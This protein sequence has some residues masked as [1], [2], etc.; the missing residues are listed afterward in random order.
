MSYYIGE[1]GLSREEYVTIICQGYLVLGRPIPAEFW[2]EW[3]AISARK[4]SADRLLEIPPQPMQVWAMMRG[5]SEFPL[6]ATGP[7]SKG[8]IVLDAKAPLT[9]IFLNFQLRRADGTLLAEFDGDIA[10]CALVAGDVLSLTLDA[11]AMVKMLEA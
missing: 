11:E 5:G 6:T 9:G 8:S 10:G 4:A 7:A 1:G 2:D 3:D